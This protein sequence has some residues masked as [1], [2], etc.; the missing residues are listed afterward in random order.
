MKFEGYHE[1]LC[2]QI[3]GGKDSDIGIWGLIN[4]NPLYE[5]EILIHHLAIVVEDL[6]FLDDI[7]G[8]IQCIN[9]IL[10]AL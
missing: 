3:P 1:F 10:K 5:P 4:L 2:R 9:T 6:C 7:D 8:L